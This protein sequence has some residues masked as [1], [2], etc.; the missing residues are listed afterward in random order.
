MAT[1]AMSKMYIPCSAVD[2]VTEGTCSILPV[3]I[4]YVNQK[5][6]SIFYGYMHSSK[7]AQK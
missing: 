7:I 4:K 3:Y 1:L 6:R 2:K 5:I